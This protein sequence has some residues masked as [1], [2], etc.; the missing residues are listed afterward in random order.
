MKL[1]TTILVYS[2]ML[3]LGFISCETKKQSVEF[4]VDF[5]NFISRHDM[6]WD[7]TPDSWTTAPFSGNGNVGF[8]LYQVESG[9]KNNISL[10]VGRHDYYDHRLPFEG[11]QMIWVYRTRLPLGHFNLESKG[12]V[13]GADLRLGL[14][15]AELSG[16]ITTSLGSYQVHALT[17]TNSDIIYFET[18]ATQGES[19][20]KIGRNTQNLSVSKKER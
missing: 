12:E 6:V 4:N 5:E 11:Q 18:D 7:R 15:D 20:K 2:I 16:T 13:T 8:L 19:I 17:H 3:V 14:W 1:K 10:H 9:P